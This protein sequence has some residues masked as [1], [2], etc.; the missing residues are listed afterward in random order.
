MALSTALLGFIFSLLIS[1]IVIYFV[2]KLMG[3][4]EGF[5]TALLAALA[6]SFIYGVAA[7]FLGVGFL[8]TTIAGIAWLIALSSLY[9]IGWLKS[10]AV[11]VLI[12]ILSGLVSILL[13]TLAG[14][15]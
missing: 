12:W 9:G 5:V 6:G 11:A 4:E 7:Y 8:A 2:T 3:E 10:F 13:P 14:P 1:T 15:V